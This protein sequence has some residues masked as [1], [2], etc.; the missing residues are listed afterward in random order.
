MNSGEMSLGRE[1][2][3]TFLRR[4]PYGSVKFHLRIGL[5]AVK[6]SFFDLERSCGEMSLGVIFMGTF[7][8][9]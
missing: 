2:E 3:F 8:P 5:V 1:H 4:I 9:K 6:S 7:P